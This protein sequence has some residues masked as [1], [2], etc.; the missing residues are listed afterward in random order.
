MDCRIFTAFKKPFVMKKLF[1]SIRTDSVKGNPIKI[2]FS[3]KRIILFALFFL[4]I[5]PGLRSQNH[6]WARWLP[7]VTG[8]GYADAITSLALD[9][10]GN[11]YTIGNISGLVSTGIDTIGP[12]YPGATDVF[13]IKYNSEGEKVWSK[14]LGGTWYDTPV[15]LAVNDS[16]VF[17]SAAIQYQTLKIEDS[18]MTKVSSRPIIHFDLDG[19]LKSIYWHSENDAITGMYCSDSALHI[20]AERNIYTMKHF[21]TISGRIAFSTS[22]YMKITD[23]HIYPDNEKLVAGLFRGSMSYRDTTLSEY[24]PGAQGDAHGFIMKL[25]AHDSLQWVKTFGRI[26]TNS[27]AQVMIALVDDGTIYYAFNYNNSNIVF[28]GGSL[29]PKTAGQQSLIAT[30]DF[31]GEPLWFRSIDTENSYNGTRTRDIYAS[32]ENVF[33]AGDYEGSLR[34]ETEEI[35]P[36]AGFR[37]FIL[38]INNTGDLQWADGNGGYSGTNMMRRIIGDGQGNLY[39]SGMSFGATNILFGCDRYPDVHSGVLFHL[40]DS[41]P[42]GLPEVNFKYKQQDED[43]F[44]TGILKNASSW[45]WNF[46]DGTNELEGAL[47]PSYRFAEKGTYEVTFK[48][49]NKCGT[50][51]AID[52]ILIP[53]L[54]QLIPSKSAATNY[55]VGDVHGAGFTDKTSFLLVAEDGTEIPLANSYYDS[56]SR[57]HFIIEFKNA[58]N[59]F[60]DLVMING[61]ESDTLE[62]A[63][64]I[65]GG[66]EPEIVVSVDGPS[67]ALRNVPNHYRINISNQSSVNGLGIPVFIIIPGNPWIYMTNP[68]QDDPEMTEVLDELDGRFMDYTTEDGEHY[69]F[70]FF[71]VPILPSESD[72]FFDLYIEYPEITFGEIRIYTGD[73]SLSSGSGNG[74]LN[75]ECTNCILG[76]AN[77]IPDAGCLSGILSMGCAVSDALEESGLSGDQMYDMGT[78]MIAT[79]MAC[80]NAASASEIANNIARSVME[81]LGLESGGDQ[82]EENNCDYTS[83][84]PDEPMHF[85]MNIV[86]SM[87]PNEKYGILGMDENNYIHSDVLL[88][89]RITFENVDSATAAAREVFIYDTL[90]I[91]VYDLASFQWTGFGF[92]DTAVSIPSGYNEYL[93]DLDMRPQGNIIVRFEGSIDSTGVVRA[94]F[95]SL[96]TTSYSLTD[97][98]LDGF[99]PPNVNAP[100]GEGYISFSIR[101]KTN[102]PHNTRIENRASIQFDY[103]ELIQTGTFVNTIDIESPKSDLHALESF[104]RD[105]LIH[106]TWN[107]SDDESGIWFYDVYASAND[108]AFQQV[109]RMVPQNEYIF[110]GINR[111]TYGFYIVATDNAGNRETKDPVA[112]VSTKLILSSG[113][114]LEDGSVRLYPVPAQELLYLEISDAGIVPENLKLFDAS[115]R[116]VLSQDLHGAG[117]GSVHEIDIS[118]LLPGIFY[119]LLEDSYG[120][121]KVLP[122][123]K[124]RN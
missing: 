33:V 7:Q 51:T 100:E 47:N 8:Q 21:P 93:K 26:A 94:G 45:R 66:S 20:T 123:S 105:T 41:V 75:S 111:T 28:P 81:W 18:I 72:A 54:K 52:T 97:N 43:F 89:Y 29:P 121:K 6:E 19:N 99:L 110:K 122:F 23:L 104:I 64:L 84:L 92:G 107:G 116:I 70:G 124:T 46:D 95:A 65:E 109:A 83:C 115:G 60:Y 49:T 87:D 106:L 3:T 120:G 85:A 10:E 22:Y 2:S 56:P 71:M 102:I 63:L 42:D 55:Y 39:A 36:W 114:S 24:I 1:P 11:L 16:A 17:I 96:D 34:F 27:D 58:V 57:S 35:I 25:N 44:F 40:K 86:S 9:A 15:A 113:K 38:K 53:G 14:V 61:T 88:N 48:A 73:P 67:T 108:S 90:D 13:L 74:C 37:R 117:K 59:G 77:I 82:D 62:N 118:S 12:V 5:S 32:G 103:N 112:E 91:N 80:S 98:I 79:A 101:S 119:M 31:N 50:R 78:G 69:K 30:L 68:F 76:M 4:L